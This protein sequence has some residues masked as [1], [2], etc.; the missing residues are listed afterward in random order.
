M[1]RK[2]GFA[3]GL[4]LLAIA[5]PVTAGGGFVVLVNRSNPITSISRSDIKRTLTG[6]IKQWESG[7]VVQL[8][9]IPGDAPETQYLGSLVDLSARDLIARIQEQVFKGELRRPAILHGPADCAAFARA[10]PG[11]LCAAS[12]NEPVPPEAH[13]L[14]VH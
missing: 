9:I 2:I 4:L 3:L 11:A 1:A 14:A 10:T 12:E 7:A 6:G 13:V 8:G 5:R